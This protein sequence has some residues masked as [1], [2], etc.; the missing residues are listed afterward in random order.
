MGGKVI[1]A[2]YLIVLLA[3]VI[4]AFWVMD[5][6]DFDSVRPIE[7]DGNY[8]LHPQEQIPRTAP[9]ILIAEDG[10]LFLFYIDT[11][12]VNVYTDAGEFL[13]GIQFPD[14]RNGRSDMMV[15][16]GLLYVDARVSG[17]YVFDGTALLRFE[18]QSIHNGNYDE[19]EAVFTGEADHADGGCI[20]SYVEETNRIVRSGSDG[21]V[22]VI[23]FPQRKF[24]GPSFVV[25]AAVMLFIGRFIWEEKHDAH[26]K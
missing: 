16:D 20:Y 3:L 25:L 1:K 24:D 18:E 10:K 23:Q 11:E 22:V 14:G 8:Q 4:A 7:G 15:K 6:E 17:I 21:P 12:L 26:H 9:D 19:L 2:V 13:Y 5:S